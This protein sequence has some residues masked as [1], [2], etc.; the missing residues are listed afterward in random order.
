MA[1]TNTPALIAYSVRQRDGAP[2]VWTRIGAVF[3]H[4]DGKGFN[5]MLDALPMGRKI[6]VMPPK[7]DRK[8]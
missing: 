6:V 8:E 2:D 4:A 3:A 1:D 5:L 7:D